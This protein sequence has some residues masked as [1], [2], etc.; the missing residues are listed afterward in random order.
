MRGDISLFKVIKN[1]IPCRV[2]TE[3]GAAESVTA[4]AADLKRDLKRLSGGNDALAAENS[5]GAVAVKVAAAP[6]GPLSHTEGFV[7][8]IS[9]S[10][11]T[12]TGNDDLGAIY[13]IYA[14]E[15]KYLGISPFCRM[16]DIFPK[17]KTDL[18]IENGN[19][20]DYPKTYRFR[21]WFINDEDLL[22]E[23]RDSGGK[24]GIDYYFYDDVM[25]VSV[26]EMVL[27]TALRLR[28]NLIKP[29]R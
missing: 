1:G 14:F 23:F 24:R 16:N 10:G 25:D 5:A 22:C 9:D 6:E 18:E 26:L 7:I 8:E 13:G 3:S 28:M 4:A 12:I 27:E 17:A 20:S 19:Y 29:A 11:V 21:G 2:F 15:E